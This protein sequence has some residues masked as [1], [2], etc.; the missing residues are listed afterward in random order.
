MK[1]M[2]L[3][4]SRRLPLAGATLLVAL[5]VTL[6]ASA[7]VIEYENNGKKY[8]TL[9]HKGLTVIVTRMP[10]HVAGFGVLQVSISNGSDIYWVVQPEGFSYLYGEQ[11]IAGISAGQFVDV[12]LS[13][14]SS[15]DVTKLVTSYENNLYGIPNMRTTNGYEQRRQGAFAFGVSSK[16]KAAATASALA[17]AQARLAP[18]QSTDGSVFIPLNHEMKT[19]GGGRIVFRSGNERFEFNPD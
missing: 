7:Q 19:L 3:P 2:P 15:S 13:K 10:N 17:L 4:C 1:G 12:L 8:Q 5:L 11:A 6:V 18:G 14:G 16:L 9:T